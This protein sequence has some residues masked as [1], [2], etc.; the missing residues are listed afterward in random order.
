MVDGFPYCELSYDYNECMD[1]IEGGYFKNKPNSNYLNIKN[2][3]TIIKTGQFI[4]VIDNVAFDCFLK[5]GTGRKLFVSLTGGVG[6]SNREKGAIFTR[7][8]YYTKTVDSW[9]CIDDPM[10][11][12]YNVKFGWFLGNK[13]SDFSHSI[14]VIIKEVCSS[15]HISEDDVIF[16]S[17][18]SGGTASIRAS[19]YFNHTTCVVINP[20][21]N[22]S[23]H[24]MLKAIRDKVE[25]DSKELE[26]RIDILGIVESNT[27]ND[28]F[29]FINLRSKWD[30]EV[31]YKYITTYFN[32][33]R[34]WGYSEHFNISLI[35]YSA[36]SAD[37]HSAQDWISLFSCIVWFVQ[38]KDDLNFK[39]RCSYCYF[40]IDLWREEYL[41]RLKISYNCISKFDEVPN[42]LMDIYVNGLECKN[43]DYLL[44]DYEQHGNLES[45]REAAYRFNINAELKYVEILSNDKNN[46]EI[47]FDLLNVYCSLNDPMSCVLLARRISSKDM[48]KSKSLYRKA[49]QFGLNWVKPEYV[50]LLIKDDYV[51]NGKEILNIISSEKDN[52]CLF[53]R[54]G[55][56]YRDGRIVEKNTNVMMEIYLDCYNRGVKW[57]L[58]ECVDALC[59]DKS[60][61][62]IGMSLINDYIF[63]PDIKKR[64]D[65]YNSRKV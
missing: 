50:D 41:N 26:K 22:L 31:E 46:D 62:S 16:Y 24:P 40:L 25:Y 27:Q 56:I 1:Q 49:I 48:E 5:K 42:E 58:L 59:M 47:I 20:Q 2:S 15:L 51:G 10:C 65:L 32:I 52:A 61:Y 35:T 53:A 57:A 39:D 17:S 45:L 43:S 12:Y 11:K 44:L 55:R 28:Y 13:D 14:S 29:F 60:T 4:R 63:D 30:F 19:Q 6:G 54:L 23:A 8:T 37:P 36:I 38:K 21:L 64:F 18:S 33:D 9:L 7:W 34:A 3:D